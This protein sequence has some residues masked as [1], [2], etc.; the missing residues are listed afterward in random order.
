M[1]INFQLSKVSKE[2]GEKTP[3]Q[4]VTKKLLN[5]DLSETEC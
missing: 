2:T 1:S 4:H 5:L 3:N